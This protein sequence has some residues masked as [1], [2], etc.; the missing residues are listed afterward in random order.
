MLSLYPSGRPLQRAHPALRAHTH[1]WARTHAPVSHSYWTYLSSA[2]ARTHALSMQVGHAWL[3]RAL[4]KLLTIAA[5]LA[6]R[7][8]PCSSEML[9]IA[10]LLTAAPHGPWVAPPG[11][12]KALD[13]AKSRCGGMC[14]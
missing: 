11:V 8:V 4:A 9:T 6:C 12:R 1:A 7:A 10:A 14:G 2:A 13:Q 5:L 3:C